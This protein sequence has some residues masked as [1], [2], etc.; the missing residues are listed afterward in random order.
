MKDFSF[1]LSEFDAQFNRRH[2]PENPGNLDNAAQYLLDLGGKRIRPVCV[3]M[4]N[5]LFTEINED[6]FHAANAI[7]LFHNFS[8]IHDDIMDKAPLRRGKP[9]VHAK[10]GEATALL[11]GDV[12]LVGAYDYLNRIRNEHFHKILTIFNQTAKEV[13]EGQQID[14][15]FEK[16]SAVS[17]EEYEK[18]ITLKTSVLLAASLQIGAIIG[19]AGLGNQQHIYA[20]GR[21]LGMAFQVQDD[22]LDAFGDPGKFGKQKGGDIL[23]NKM[24]FLMIHALNVATP[25]Q[26]VKLTTLLSTEAHDKVE[27]VLAIYV[28]CGVDA[29]ARELKEQYYTKA[30]QCLEDIAVLSLRKT[31]LQSFAEYLLNRDK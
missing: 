14:M 18:M 11:S 29:W 24:T 6:A 21:N 17:F 27:Q 30:L 5:E 8:L 12:M 20:F 13:C 31:T 7:E 3:L 2:F 4:G 19:G 16:Q 22:Y 28:D 9:T 15:N 23:A 1:L 25:E 26:K 10:F